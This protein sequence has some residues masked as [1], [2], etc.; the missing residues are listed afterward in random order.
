MGAWSRKASV[1]PSSRAP[2]VVASPP[3]TAS[4]ASRVV[5]HSP[6]WPG[7]RLEFGAL[8]GILLL[9]AALRLVQIT[10]VPPGISHDEAMYG[11]DARDVV[12]LGVHPIYFE[13]NNGGREP[14]YIYLSALMMLLVGP[15][16]LALR[17]VS[18]ACGLGTILAGHLLFRRL[19]GPRVAIFASAWLAVNFWHLVLSR[20]SFRAITLPLVLTLA[21]LLLW[22]GLTERRRWA[23]PVGGAL[24][25][26][27]QYTYFADRAVPFL[28]LAFLA[29]L[30]VVRREWLQACW[31]GVLVYLGVALL[32]FLPLGSYYL[33]HPHIF[34]SRFEQ[35]ASVGGNDPAAPPSPLVNV[36]DALGMF[37]VRGDYLWGRNISNRPVFDGIGAAFFYLGL[38]LALLQLRRPAMGLLLIWSGVM[39]LP[40]AL[41]TSAPHYLRAVGLI[42]AI[43]ALPALGLDWLLDR[44]LPWLRWLG[45]ARAGLVTALLVGWLGGTAGSVAYEYF[46]LWAPRPEV[47]YGFHSEMNAIGRYLN[48]EVSGDPLVMLSSEY[49]DHPSTLF[50]LKRP[51]DLRWFNGTQSL[52]VPA[53]GAREVLYLFPWSARPAELERYFDPATRV[54]E[55]PG[56][57]GTVAFVAYRVSPAQNQALAERLRTPLGE[58]VPVGPVVL[59]G[60]EAG[61]RVRPGERLPLTLTWQVQQPADPALDLAWFSHLLDRTGQRWGI[62]DAN[63]Y[64]SPQWQPGDLV[65]GRYD[66]MV[67]PRAPPGEYRLA[68]GLYDRRSGSRLPTLRPDGNVIFGRVKVLATAPPPPARHPLEA[69][70][71]TIRLLGY[72]LSAPRCQ[73]GSCTATLRLLWQADAP[74]G[75]A[76]TVFVHIVDVQ[77]RIVAQAD[78]PPA[79]YR[80]PT[81]LWEAGEVV[82][83]ER[84]VPLPAGATRLLIGLYRPET[85]ER[86]SG[87]QGDAVA[88]PLSP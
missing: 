41:S 51:F 54:A 82:A 47:Y 83:D 49:R 6:A 56:P 21:L 33:G 44:L 40:T 67:D 68:V 62:G 18:V 7:W 3:L 73:D 29:Y 35:V 59:L 34:F 48:E 36:V 26:L 88:I 2:R 65:R 22:V 86:L 25:G 30:W 84:Q 87:P 76:Y 77:G 52:V 27:V 10:T 81:D 14:L 58:P 78:G 1:L 69:R 11:L 71:G 45:R 19:F 20:N 79:D 12:Q 72:D 61:S 46:V 74:P 39:I 75:V 60:W 80:Q 4:P 24:F 23:W 28:L 17:L 53:A 43:F 8:V 37:S 50:L 70:F 85:G 57:A 63:E 16:P 9:A 5:P 42:P 31:R 13:R 38:V 64:A 15:E 32:V 66:L 55:R